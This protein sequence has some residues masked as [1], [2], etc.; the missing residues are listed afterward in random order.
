MTRISVPF[1]AH[2]LAATGTESAIALGVGGSLLVL[3][4]L[5][6]VLYASR[7]IRSSAKGQ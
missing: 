4:I 1:Q 2:E 6:V 5:I 7:R 3:G